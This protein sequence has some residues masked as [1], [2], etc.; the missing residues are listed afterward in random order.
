MAASA[1]LLGHLKPAAR[2]THIVVLGRPQ[3]KTKTSIIQD[4]LQRRIV[5]L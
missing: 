2:R 5:L 3:V 4:Y 1:F